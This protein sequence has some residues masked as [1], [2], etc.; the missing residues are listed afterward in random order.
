MAYGYEPNSIMSE[1][2]KY[3]YE[4]ENNEYYVENIRELLDKIEEEYYEND[5]KLNNE[6]ISVIG[7]GE[8]PNKKSKIILKTQYPYEISWIINELYH[9]YFN[10]D[11]IIDE[12]KFYITISYLIEIYEK[13]INDVVLILNFVTSVSMIIIHPDHIIKDKFKIVL[14]NLP[15]FGKEF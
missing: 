9:I 10:G 5:E 12:Y 1:V 2:L 8:L 14:N 13:K 11:I 4:N 3:V 6:Y 15:D 7:Y